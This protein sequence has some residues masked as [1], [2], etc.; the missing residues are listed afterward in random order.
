[1]LTNDFELC[2]NKGLFLYKPLYAV[3]LPMRFSDAELHINL[4]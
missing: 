4:E 1:M 3:L 2:L